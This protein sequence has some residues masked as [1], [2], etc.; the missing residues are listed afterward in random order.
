MMCPEVEA[1]HWHT[2][3]RFREGVP[4]GK[5]LNPMCK[6]KDQPSPYTSDARESAERQALFSEFGNKWKK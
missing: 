4:R 3:T 6:E 5:Q 1:T 2:V